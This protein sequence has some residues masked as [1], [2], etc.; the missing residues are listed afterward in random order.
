MTREHD[1]I[2]TEN[3][4]RIFDVATNDVF[5][6]FRRDSEDEV[7]NGIELSTDVDVGAASWTP[8]FCVGEKAKMSVCVGSSVIMHASS[9]VTGPMSATS[10]VYGLSGNGKG[11]IGFW[12][13]HSRFSSFPTSITSS[14]IRSQNIIH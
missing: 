4:N 11:R 10:F 7:G 8:F 5:I 14:E 6:V 13:R 3:R 12:P 2:G 9:H 1:E